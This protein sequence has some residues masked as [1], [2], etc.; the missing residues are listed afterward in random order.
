MTENNETNEQE[1]AKKK[2]S[3][4]E[5]IQKTVRSKEKPNSLITNAK[6]NPA[7]SAKKNAKP[8][9]KTS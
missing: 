2:I 8:T 5:V 6:G 4:K 9:I 3:L 1:T 7:Q